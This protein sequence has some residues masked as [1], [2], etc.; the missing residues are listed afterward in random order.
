MGVKMRDCKWG[1]LEY[2]PRGQGINPK[3]WGDT[4]E[5]AKEVL[6]NKDD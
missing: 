2:V 4:I 1:W 5:G 3:D 6:V